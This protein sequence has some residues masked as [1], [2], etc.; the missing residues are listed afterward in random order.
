MA[1]YY[2]IMS[3][4]PD[5]QLDSPDKALPTSYLREQILEDGEMKGSD[6]RMVELFFLMSDCR[7]LII[8]LNDNLAELPHMGNWN[9]QELQE[10]IADALEDEF[11]D[12]PRFPPFMAEFVREYFEKQQETGYFPEDRLMIRYWHYLK[13][14]GTG[15]VRQWAELSLDVSNTLTALLCQQQGWPVEQYTYDY[16]PAQIDGTLMTQLHEIA[17]DKDPV[18]KER[19]IDALKWL[20]IEDET[21]FEPFDINALYAYLLKTEMLERWTRLDPKQ[22]KEKFRMIIEDL[23]QNATVPA[24][25]TAYM[26]KEEGLYN[27]NEK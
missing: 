20:W 6:L 13:K 8:L 10:M 11:E 14:Q 26:P 21:F 1:N 15:F 12:D 9:K 18:E 4:L 25:F 24:E 27:K 19:R 16:D 5:L 3:G 2:F 7:N 23:R 22:G 17:K